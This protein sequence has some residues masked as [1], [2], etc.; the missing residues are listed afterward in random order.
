MPSGEEFEEQVAAHFERL[1]YHATLTPTTNDFGADIILYEQIT[2][3]KIVVQVKYLSNGNV[4]VNAVQEVT[5]AINYY[6][7][8]EGWVVTNSRF[9]SRAYE[10]AR[11]N[12][13]RLI[14]NF[15]PYIPDET[16][17]PTSYDT[18]N[19]TGPLPPTPPP[20]TDIGVILFIFLLI[21]G[22][23]FSAFILLNPSQDSELD[24][25]LASA[26]ELF[27]SGQYSEAIKQYNSALELDPKN[28]EIYFNLGNCY[29]LLGSH[30]EAI[31][32]FNKAIELDST[33]TMAWYNKGIAYLKLD[34]L[35]EASAAF[36]KAYSL[37]STNEMIKKNY[38]L[39]KKDQ[40]IQ[41]PISTRRI[42]Q[43]T[44][45]TP[46]PT[47]VVT[48]RITPIVTTT[49]P[50]SI[51][52]TTIPSTI[53]PDQVQQ[54][55]GIESPPMEFWGNATISGNPLPLNSIIEAKI[56]DV[57]S[58]K[59]ITKIEGKYGNDG[60]FD[61]RL[62]VYIKAEE[63]SQGPKM[64]TFWNNGKQA[65]QTVQYKPGTSIKLNLEFN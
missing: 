51:P 28:P 46:S 17:T 40:P 39:Y 21:I 24:T 26:N 41:Q 58:G 47:F 10:L 55:I 49:I 63:I 15:I 50:T 7:A 45:I 42:I 25:I 53:S 33:F 5:T 54:N 11:P 3:K 9:T 59:I 36:T 14:E 62:R 18:T 37:D 60:P 32:Y 44:R 35:S 16:P 65:K 43:T 19:T 34:K 48:N 27:Q 22:G 52:T 13:I 12:N 61:E 2:N 38:E 30:S 64:V 57:E 56:G 1:G 20:S 31:W 29:G 8:S 4:G 6:G 23:V